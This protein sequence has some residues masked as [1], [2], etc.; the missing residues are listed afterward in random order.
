MIRRMTT[1]K[2]KPS[3]S[4][5][6]RDNLLHVIGPYLFRRI[7]GPGGTFEI[8]SDAYASSTARHAQPQTFVTVKRLLTHALPPRGILVADGQ[9]DAK[10]GTGVAHHGA[11]DDAEPIGA[12]R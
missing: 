6:R 7:L 5:A 4:F 12:R 10:V 11:Q 9:R 1:E 8:L 3:V 2:P